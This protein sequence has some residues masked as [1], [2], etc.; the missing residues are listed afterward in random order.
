MHSELVNG[1]EILGAHGLRRLL[2]QSVLGDDRLRVV[3]KGS[4]HSLSRIAIGIE[5]QLADLVSVHKD[6]PP[7]LT[8]YLWILYSSLSQ[9][10]RPQV[11]ATPSARR[12]WGSMESSHPIDRAPETASVTKST[13]A[14]RR[15]LSDEIV[16]RAA[17][18]FDK[19][20]YA[21]TSFQDIADAVGVAR[22]SLYH[23]FDSKETILALIVE[24]TI[25]ARDAIMARV[26]AMTDSPAVR[27][28][29]LIS[30]LGTWTS[31]HPAGLRL[32][33]NASG[34][35]PE[36]TRRRDLRSRRSMFELLS[37]VIADGID[38]GT[39]K[40]VDERE[41]AATVIAALSGLQYSSIGGVEMKAS[42]AARRMVT[43]LLGGIVR[44]SGAGPS[45]FDE[46]MDAIRTGLITLERHARTPRQD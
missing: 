21:E 11:G 2:G 43:L 28:E 22:P 13:S 10:N 41:T 38:E 23:Y 4:S 27:L 37:S 45:N 33:L 12:E 1:A 5:E 30:D 9:G 16:D 40:V 39:F 15:Q 3:T 24:R 18:L 42:V 44:E 25:E 31:E 32:L 29:L 20:G 26:V 17:E 19:R 7:G 6:F 14:R 36:P 8:P 35:I 46:A 34:S